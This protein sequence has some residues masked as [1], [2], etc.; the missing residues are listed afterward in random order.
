MVEKFTE[1][2]VQD[3]IREHGHA[4]WQALERKASIFV[5]GNSKNMP[6]QVRQAFMDVCVQH[7]QL[8]ELEAAQL[9]ERMEKASRYQTE[10]WS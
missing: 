7:G 4:V 6:Q 9:M 5:A 10:C 1:T 8:S 2:Y 3:K